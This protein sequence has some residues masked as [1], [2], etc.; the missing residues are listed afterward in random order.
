SLCGVVV[1]VMVVGC[2]MRWFA[3]PGTDHAI[4]IALSGLF[5]ATI[6]AEFAT[7]FNNAMM[8][9]LAPPEKLGK[10]SGTGWA[11]CYSGGLV[12]LALTLGFL[13]ASPETGKTIAGLAP[14]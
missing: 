7:V 11:V 12:S 3:R 10:L 1:C 4:A 5:V 13:A 9:T 6:G 14:A 8:P 2:A